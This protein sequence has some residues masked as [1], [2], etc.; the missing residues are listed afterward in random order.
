MKRILTLIFILFAC[1]SGTAQEINIS[2]NRKAVR[3]S[4]DVLMYVTPIASLT[5]ALALQDWQGLKQGALAGVSTIGMTYA[6]KHIIK[7]E[8]PDGSD[9]HSFPS[10][11]TSISFTGA[12][13]IQRR[14]GWKWGIPA[15]AVS[16]YVGWSR[17]FAK[18][19][20]WWDVVAGAAIG[21]GSAYI[22]T[23]PFATKHNLSICPVASDKHFGVLVQLTIGN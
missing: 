18:R 4:G 1:L 21:A 22:F 10:M 7:K 9:N 19:H 12:A 20:D 23:R 2:G 15:Y 5:T 8:R 16:T 14:Y 3:R 11:H 13:F 6:L 17:T